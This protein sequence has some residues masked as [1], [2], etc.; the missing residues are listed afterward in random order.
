M[1]D[2]YPNRPRELFNPDDDPDLSSIDEEFATFHHTR[3]EDFLLRELWHAYDCARKGKRKTVDEHRFELNDMENLIFLRDSIIQRRYKPSR[4]V[5]FIVRDPVIREIVAAPFRDRVIHHFLY[6]VC[7]DW[8]DRRFIIDSYSCRVGKGTLFGQQRLSTHIRRATKNHTRPAFVVK[9]DIQ[10]YFMS[11]D[12]RKLYERICWGLDRQF[13]YNPNTVPHVPLD[14]KEYY[15]RNGIRCHASDRDQLYQVVKFLWHQIIH[16]DP[17]KNIII[18]G[19]RSD[20]R[21][22]PVSKSLFNQPKGRGIVIGN[23]TSQLLSNIFLD[24]LDRYITFDLGYKHYGRYVD[25]FFIIVPDEQREQ[26]LR[27][28]NAIQKFLERELN[29]TLHPKKQYRQPVDKGIPFIGTVVYPRF[30]VPSRRSRRKAFE[31]A[32]KLSTRGEGDIDGFVSRMGTTK[33]INSRRFFKKLFDSFGWEYDWLPEEEYQKQ[34]AAA[35]KARAALPRKPTH[36]SNPVSSSSQHSSATTSS[37]RRTHDTS[38]SRKSRQKQRAEASRPIPISY[39]NHLPDLIPVFTQTSLLP[40]DLL[41]DNLPTTPSKKSHHSARKPQ[42]PTASKSKPKTP[43][44]SI[45]PK[46][47]KASRKTSSRTREVSAAQ[48]SLFPGT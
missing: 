47:T 27:D 30:I 13:R 6:N 43:R 12:H 40:S 37:I 22:L 45:Q 25:D 42:Q 19:P 10:G 46:S 5:A 4:G 7:A 39:N 32:Y 36:T 31:A 15:H 18:R 24:Q 38:N 17:M 41:P 35:R 3:F 8:W 34:K 14:N 33:H 1:L 21:E 23:L 20:W 28:V 29:L 16:D 48:T 44:K 9:L 2:Q 11:L 26:L